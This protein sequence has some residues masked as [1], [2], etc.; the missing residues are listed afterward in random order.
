MTIS[1]TVH[2]N[3]DDALVAWQPEPWPVEW[4]GFMLE[5]RDVTTRAKR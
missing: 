1:V 2:A 5:I 4:E 3:Q